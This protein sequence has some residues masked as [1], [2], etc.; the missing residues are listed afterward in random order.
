M[1][2]IIL[3]VA[4]ISMSV[5]SFAQNKNDKWA[6]TMHVG[7]SGYS[8]DLGDNLFY[9]FN[10]EKSTYGLSLARYISPFFDAVAHVNYTK[11]AYAKNAQENF[12]GDFYHYGVRL[13]L[14]LNNGKLFK[15]N[16]LI[17]PYF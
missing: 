11:W 6:I 8:G 2:K 5:L 4:L 12:N 14:K 7:F 17:A 15:E 13:H 1:K 16:S 3:L 9:D 10:S